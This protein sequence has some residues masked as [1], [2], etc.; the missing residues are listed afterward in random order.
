[1]EGE[2]EGEKWGKERKLEKRDRR[3]AGRRKGE[4]NRSFCLAGVM[5][6]MFCSS[7]EFI[8]HAGLRVPEGWERMC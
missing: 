1:M 4:G 7:Q 2:R 3:R 8:V 5:F 6:S